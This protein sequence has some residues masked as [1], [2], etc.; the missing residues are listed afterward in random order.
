MDR[1]GTRAKTAAAALLLFAS[2]CS[3][4]SPTPATAATPFP[5]R[6][7]QALAPANQDAALESAVDDFIEGMFERN[8]T[9]AAWAGRHEYDG[10]LPDYS[11]EGLKA[12]ATWLHEQR[13]RFAGFADDALG[14]EGRFHR[15][16]VVSVI[17][18]ELF[19]TEQSGF[20]Y[21]NPAFY[22]W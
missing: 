20:P 6:S 5:A 3:S 22:T 17:D 10:K 14:A 12:T 19:W 18:G 4:G 1:Q 21:A 15:D 2:A 13:Q 16:Y 9:F 8:P 7:G 11:A